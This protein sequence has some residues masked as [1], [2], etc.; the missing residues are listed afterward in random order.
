MQADFYH[1]LFHSGAQR[2]ED[3]RGPSDALA[4]QRFRVYRN[5]VMH[6]LERAL[7]DIF[8][9]C[10]QLVGEAFFRA[11]AHEYINQYP[12]TSPI[13][14]DYGDHFADFVRS[15][16]PAQSLPY[17]PDLCQLEHHLLHL[18]HQA[19]VTT[20]PLAEAQQRLTQVRNPSALRL[21]LATNCRLLHSPYAIGSL[22][23]AHDHA[24]PD[25]SQI[26]VNTPES[27]LLSKDGLYGCCHVISAAEYEFLSALQRGATLSHALPEED[28]FELGQTLAKLMRWQVLSAITED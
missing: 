14:S 1:A 13:L 19:E 25:L 6:S 23:R 22:Y 8:P 11:M 18:T 21:A 5:N 20:L 4:E 3:I 17:L 12:P 15:F 9:V 16:L 10:Q 7:G 27:L 2:L 24:T 28:T 26:R